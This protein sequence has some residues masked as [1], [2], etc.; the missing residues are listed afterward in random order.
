MQFVRSAVSRVRLSN[1]FGIRRGLVV[2]S[3]CLS[4]P[5]D[6]ATVASDDNGAQAAATSAALEP[7]AKEKF[8][9][10]QPV[11]RFNGRVRAS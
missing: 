8:A 11:T 10:Q 6:V 9:A 4:D 5:T 7:G 1:T 2:Y 3:R